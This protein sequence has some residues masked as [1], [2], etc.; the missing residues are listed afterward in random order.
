MA[1]A[2]FKMTVIE[3]ASGIV[4]V[5]FATLMR[6]DDPS[7][8]HIIDTETAEEA[9]VKAGTLLNAADVETHVMLGHPDLVLTPYPNYF[10]GELHFSPDP[11]PDL[12][13]TYHIGTFVPIPR[14]I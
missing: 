9:V 4:E 5:N 8:R 3:N 11:D 1:Y 10:V 2:I 13:E 12:R 14:K 7:K 6:F